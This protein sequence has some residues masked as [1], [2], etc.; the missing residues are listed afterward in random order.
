M[1]ALSSVNGSNFRPNDLPKKGM[2]TVSRQRHRQ[3]FS[4]FVLLYLLPV[5][6]LKLCDMLE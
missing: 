2:L 3:V 4:A 6:Q 5:L 1:L